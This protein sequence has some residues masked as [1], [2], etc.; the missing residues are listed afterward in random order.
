MGPY[1]VHTWHRRGPRDLSR[2]HHDSSSLTFWRLFDR[3]SVHRPARALSVARRRLLGCCPRRATL[4][5]PAPGGRASTL[6]AVGSAAAP[7]APRRSRACYPCSRTGTQ[8]GRCAGAPGVVKAVGGPRA[9]LAPALRWT[10]TGDRPSRLLNATGGTSLASERGSIWCALPR[11]R[12]GVPRS[13]NQ[14]IGS[15]AGETGRER[16]RTRPR[17]RRASRFARLSSDGELHLILRV[18]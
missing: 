12:F 9:F 8:M 18:I 10:P 1:V 5:R 15:A 2:A 4:R 14:R 3:C 17:C 7:F 13:A 6:R 11:R 16:K